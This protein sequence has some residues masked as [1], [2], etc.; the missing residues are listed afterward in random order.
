VSFLS[1]LLPKALITRVYALYSL[2]L[3]VFVGG[4]LFLFYQFQS[5][6]AIEDAQRS[7]TMLIEVAAQTVSDSA[8]IGDYDTIQRVL[9]KSIYRSQFESAAFIDLSGAVI[10]SGNASA[11]PSQAPAWLRERIAAQLYD[12]NRTISVGGKDY[13]VLRLVFAA[14]NIADGLWKLIAT[15]LALAGASLVGGLL[16][17]WFPLRSWLG[18]LDRVRAYEPAPEG[19]DAA[20]PVTRTDDLPLEFRPAFDILQRNAESLRRELATRE[21]AVASLRQV[22]ASMIHVSE[23]EV[24]NT[25][26]DLTALSKVIARLVAER[27]ASRLELELAKQTA[28]AANQAKS[29]FLANMSHEIRTPMNGIIGMTEL[30]LDTDL[31]PEQREFVGIVK[32][33]AAS[34]LTIINDILDFSKIEAGQLTI[35]PIPCDLRDEVRETLQPLAVQA[36]GKHLAFR[37]ELA[38]DLPACFVCDPVRL[39]QIM[40]NLTG[41]ALKFTE[42]GEI[43]FR[44]ARTAA[45]G[46][47]EMLHFSVR[48]T[49]IGIPPERMARIFEAF[50]QADSSTTRRYGGTGLGLSIT[51]RL[52]ELLGGTLWAESVLGQGS[53][54]HFTLP[55]VEQ[56]GELD[57]LV[58]DESPRDEADVVVAMPQAA[59]A[60][61]EILLAEDNPVNQKLA[62]HLLERRGYR[63][64]LAVNGRQAVAAA[65]ER[66]FAAILMDMQMPEMGGIEATQEIRAMEQARGV[67]PT[68]IIAMTANAMQGDR[69]RCLAAGMDDYLA[70]PIKA[71]QL[72]D[73]LGRW[74]R[75]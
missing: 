19:G 2:T 18:T 74:V 39:R 6:E 73:C 67:P 47:G 68:P 1:R 4:S 14:G 51:R 22:V 11:G 41:N 63:L 75:G 8:V 57:S 72:F 3:L 37:L 17:I 32:T 24:L 7:A 26:D 9:D 54:F 61:P 12:V 20:S 34:L 33:S 31:D 5:N 46:G 16:L 71:D 38:D 49:G 60:G 56:P 50:T 10:R 21:A 28:E 29:E 48:D 15:A 52:V 36:E 69:E 40:V 66:R 43:V 25:H 30:V 44:V 58:T 59:D 45:P 62:M 35:D 55:L 53:C 27:E 65:A 64:T 42:T 70:K 13:G 23:L